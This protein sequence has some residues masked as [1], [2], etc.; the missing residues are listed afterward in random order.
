[1][2]FCHHLQSSA[3]KLKLFKEFIEL[4]LFVEIYNYDHVFLLE[5]LLCKLF[6]DRAITLTSHIY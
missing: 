5:I 2:P 4:S 3:T 1:M 6:A